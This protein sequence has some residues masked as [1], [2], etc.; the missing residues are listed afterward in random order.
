MKNSFLVILVLGSIC[1]TQCGKKDSGPSKTELI[2]SASWKYDNSGLDINADGFIDT[3][4]PP[5]YVNDCDK[6]NVITFKADGTGTLDEGATKC[7]PGNPQTSPFTWTFKN[8][9]TVLNF[10]TALV[11]GFDGDVKILK[12]TSTELDLAKN[13][14]IGGAATVDVIVEFKH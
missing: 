7:D 8:G 2:T 9:E 5:G 13:V 6:D 4:L 1:L 3:G 11:S 12:L 10:P 14:N